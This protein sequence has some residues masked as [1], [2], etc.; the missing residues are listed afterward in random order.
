MRNQ[1]LMRQ[2]VNLHLGFALL[3][4]FACCGSASA[5]DWLQWGGPGRNF[6]SDSKGL[7]SSWPEGGP[8]RLW[9]RD[10]G[11]GHSTI[12]VEKGRLYTMYS[13]G[14][15]ETIIALEADSGKTVW[16]YS[17]EA[18]TKG[19]DY[20]QGFGPHSTPLIV[21]DRLFAVGATGKLHALD[22]RTGKVIWAHDIVGEMGGRRFD[23]GYSPS[24]LAYKNTVILPVGGTGQAVVAFNQNDGSIAWKKQ[25]FKVSPASPMLLNLEGQDQMVI[26]AAEQITGMDPNN[27]ELLWSYPHVTSYGLNISTPLW[28]DGNLLFC[29]SAYNGG[30]R[31]LKLTRK[32]GKTTASEVWFSNKVRVHF[33]TMIRLGDYVYCASGDFGPA[34]FTAV[35]VKTGEVAWRDRSF[36]RATPLYADGKLILMDEDGVL[37]LATVTPESLKVI[38]KVQ[39]LQ[40]IAWTV[41]T[42]S[43]TRLYVRDRKTIM[44]LDL[45]GSQAVR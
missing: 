18:P 11:E 34:P 22:K 45:G 12:L 10:L 16:Q 35:N 3:G 37:V 43:G 26:F 1:S 31:V 15:Q 24:P 23:R 21:G 14:E 17:Y 2:I 40:H 32:D 36:S 6:M 25:D 39:L 8:R 44:A 7:A 29:S 42:L 20:S 28:C 4:L 9:T 19:M 5:Q 38:S 41:P 30:S 33:G 13:K 27:G